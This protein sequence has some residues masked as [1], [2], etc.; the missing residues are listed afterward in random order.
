MIISLNKKITLLAMTK[1]A[2]TSIESALAPH[3]HLV[4][5]KKPIVKHISCRRY[6]RFVV[7]YLTEIGFK[8]FETTCVIREPVDWLFSWYKYRSRDVIRDK[9]ESTAETSFDEFCLGYIG[10][11]PGF[12]KFGRQSEFVQNRKNDVG[13]HHLFRYEDLDGYIKF[14]ENRFETTLEVEHLNRSPHRD[15]A[16]SNDVHQKVRDYLMPEYYLYE[17]AR[18]V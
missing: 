2:S 10:E 15:F 4:F 8:N 6:E 17:G 5:Q 9:R 3:C 11:I 16:L 1:T 12:A 18:S 7:P 13:I 14:L